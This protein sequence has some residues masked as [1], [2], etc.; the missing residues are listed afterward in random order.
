MKPSVSTLA[1]TPS[2]SSSSTEDEPSAGSKIFESRS[3][4][5]TISL[6]EPQDPHVGTSGPHTHDRPPTNFSWLDK[7]LRRMGKFS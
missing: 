3:V 2:S 5:V 7:V 1:L 4:P 6:D